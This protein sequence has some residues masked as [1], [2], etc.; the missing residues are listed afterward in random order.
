MRWNVVIGGQLSSKSYKG[1]LPFHPELVGK[2]GLLTFG[3]ILI[4]PFI[5]LYVLTK[6]LPPWQANVVIEEELP[7]SETPVVGK[8]ATS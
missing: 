7:P 4:L 6:L 8:L 5:I 1:L 3:F 2:E